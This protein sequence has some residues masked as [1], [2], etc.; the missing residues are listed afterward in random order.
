ML[1]L[2][3]DVDVSVNC[4][5]C[6]DVVLKIDDTVQHVFSQVDEG[7]TS[8]AVRVFFCDAFPCNDV[9]LAF[10]LNFKVWTFAVLERFFNFLSHHFAAWIFVEPCDPEW[11]GTQGSCARCNDCHW[12]RGRRNRHDRIGSGL[13]FRCLWNSEQLT[14]QVFQL[15]ALVICQMRM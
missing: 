14:K 10:F 3:G 11:H 5:T 12:T 15:F 4:G 2:G 1:E 9:L 13:R 8:T 7:G 6:V